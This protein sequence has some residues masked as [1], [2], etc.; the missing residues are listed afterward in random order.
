MSGKSPMAK[1]NRTSCRNG[2]AMGPSLYFYQML[3]SKSFRKISVEGG[4]STEVAAW[5]FRREGMRR[6]DPRGRAVAYTT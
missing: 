4:T 3:P 1:A 5:D 2:P 6:V